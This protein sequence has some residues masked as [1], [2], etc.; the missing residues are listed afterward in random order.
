M[1]RVESLQELSLHSV[2]RTEHGNNHANYSTQSGY[3]DWLKCPLAKRKIEN[4]LDGN[5]LGEPIEDD[6]ECKKY[7]CPMCG[8]PAKTWMRFAKTY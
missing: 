3:Y 7:S 4:I 5:T 2:H 8:K 1:Q 6:E